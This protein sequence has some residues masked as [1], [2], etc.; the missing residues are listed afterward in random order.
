MNLT[1]KIIAKHANRDN[2]KP[3]EIVEVS[4]DWCMANDAT[5]SLNIDIFKNEFGFTNVWDSEKI[6]FINDHQIPAD[7]VNTAAVHQKTREF[8]KNQG[9]QCH[10]SDGV[11]HQ[12]MFEKYVKPGEL[13]VAADSHT[14]S[15]GCVGAVSTG[16]G[17][18]DIAAVMGTGKTWLKV[19]E[20][21]KIDLNGILQKG[22][23]AKDVILKII[24]D[25]SASGAT[26]KTVEFSGE[27]TS[28]FSIS[29]RFTMCNMV[30]E[31]GGKSAMVAPD[32]K[33]VSMFQNK[34]IDWDFLTTDSNA[35]Y[36]QTITYN[37]SDLT[38]QVAC[39]HFV[40]NVKDIKK[41]EGIKID[42]AFLGSCT[43][44]R[45][46][47]LTIGANLLKG[48]K[49]ASDV[50]LLVTPASVDIYRE[51]LNQGIINIFLEAGAMINHPGC[52]TCWGACQGVLTKGQTMISS[53]NRNFKGRAGSPE[54]DIYLASPATVI[55][56]AIV[57]KITDPR[58]FLEDIK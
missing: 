54:S 19:P 1:E 58:K 5:I 30:I 42:Q 56:S 20:T 38:P 36:S 24:K 16:M 21:I 4:I 49:V 26:Y 55:A 11:C 34:N 22:V 41:V 7:S 39:P 9:I 52:S 6:I 50:R 14:C 46:D 13:V 53:A 25:L 45:F 3:G 28:R 10:E 44:G 18:T 15:Y 17:S 57:G 33:V 12:L 32:E 35:A 29:E 23:F 27:V 51:A 47:D 40:D 2:V 31:A 8:C 48:K 43:N 37:L